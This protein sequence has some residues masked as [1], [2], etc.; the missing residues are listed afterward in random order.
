MH[1]S[2]AVSYAVLARK[3]I[4]FL[5]TKELKQ[6][7]FAK[8]IRSKAESLERP[9]ILVDQDE[10]LNF[11][12]FNLEISEEKYSR[13]ETDYLRSAGSSE[14]VPWESFIQYIKNQETR[15]V[16]IPYAE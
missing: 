6:S 16:K 15:I 13:Y 9:L 2:T 8:N 12:K 3:P 14:K 1:A 11:N 10:Q 5:T 7:F 4:L